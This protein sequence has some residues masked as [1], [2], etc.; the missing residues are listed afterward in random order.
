MQYNWVSEVWERHPGE[1]R[2]LV[3]GEGS[4]SYAQARRSCDG[5][6]AWMRQQGM[7]PGDVVAVMS[8]LHPFLWI[9][10]LAAIKGGFRL[11]PLST[12]LTPQDLAYRFALHPPQL[13]VADRQHLPLL[14]GAAARLLCCE[15]ADFDGPPEPAAATA[16]EDPLFLFFTSG[17]TGMPKVVVH[18]HASYPQGHAT[19][20]KW[21]GLCAHDLHCNVAQPGWAK[22]AWSSF[23]APLTAGAAVYL[24][25]PSPRFRAAALLQQLQRHGVTCLCAPPTA[26]RLLILE[27][28]SAYQLRLRQCVSAGEPLESW[29]IERWREGTQLTIRDGYGQSETTLMIANLPEHIVKPGSMGR[30]VPP[31]EIELLDADGQPV[32]DLQEG[33]VA[34]RLPSRGVFAGYAGGSL[35][36]FR[37][38][39]YWTGDRAYRDGD[40]Y[41]WFVGRGDDVIKASDYRVGPFEVESVLIELEGVVEAAVVGVPHPL[42]GQEIK[43]F[44]VLQAGCSAEELMPRLSAHCRERL[45]SYQRPRR[46]EVLEE[47]PKT[48][49]GKIRR[50]ELRARPLCDSDF[51]V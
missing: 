47:M 1:S 39:Y 48:V 9:T 44:L 32:A 28:L 49:S 3:W 40:G 8:G 10:Y 38:G 33:E 19:T 18:T 46:V 26:W 27:D 24:P 5:L 50:L 4:L 17:T 37:K 31:Y 6:L 15:E 20:L 51:R 16:E 13:V 29:V 21:I 43:A 14:E 7:R 30:P 34:V 2:M 41:F 11:L 42:R 36:P 25:E 12:Q 22:F 35:E 45:A 23:F